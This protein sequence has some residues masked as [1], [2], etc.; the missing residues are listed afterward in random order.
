MEGTIKGETKGN[1]ESSCFRH[2]IEPFFSD[3]SEILILGSF[4]SV[5]SREE[6]FYYANKQN[7]FWKVLAA[8]FNENLPENIKEKKQFLKSHGIALWDV[9]ESCEIIGSSDS[10]IKSVVPSDIGVIL[11]SSKIKKIILNGGKASELF[12]KYQGKSSLIKSSMSEELEIFSLPSTSP[13]NAKFSL[14]NLI[15]LWQV[16]R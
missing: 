13:A 6:N 2:T 10:S 1:R 12:S 7:R 15:E 3:S 9:V 4:P 8:V 16:I 5:K 14:E 11:K